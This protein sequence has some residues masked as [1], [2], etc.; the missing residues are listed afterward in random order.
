MVV[1]DLNSIVKLVKGNRYREEEIYR[2][3]REEILLVECILEILSLKIFRFYGK[4]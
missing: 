1:V 2:F 4:V 3:C